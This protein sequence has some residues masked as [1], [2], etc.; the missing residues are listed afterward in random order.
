MEIK[1]VRKILANGE[2]VSPGHNP[3][4][5]VVAEIKKILLSLR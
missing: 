2:G 4:P 3:E 1:T 5:P